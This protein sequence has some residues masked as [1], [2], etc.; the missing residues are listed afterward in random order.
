MANFMQTM[1]DPI[2]QGPNTPQGVKASREYALAL[3]KGSQEPVNHW[4]QGI[5]NIVKALQGGYTEYTA[6]DQE[7]KGQSGANKALL[8]ALGINTDAPSATPSPAPQPMTQQPASP[9]FAAPPAPPNP[10]V[11][12]MPTMSVSDAP[13]PMAPQANANMPRG[14][15]NNNPGNIEDGPFAQ[16]LPGYIGSDGRFAKFASLDDG[17]AAMETLLRSYGN[18]GFNTPDAIVNRWAPPSDNNPTKAYA[19]NIAKALGVDPT[20]KIDLNNPQ[21]MATIRTAM[22]RQENGPQGFAPPMAP[23][24]AP[25]SAGVVPSSPA[26]TPPINRQALAQVLNDPWASPEAKA[27]VLKQLGPRDPIKMGKDDRLVDARTYQTLTGPTGPDMDKTLQVQKTIADTPEY[28]RY[29][30]VV[31]LVKDMTKAAATPGT[32]GDVSMLYAFAKIMDPESVVREGEYNTL[33]KLQSLPEQIRGNIDKYMK[34]EASLGPRIRQ[35]LMEA[36]YNRGDELRLSAQQRLSGYDSFIRDNRINPKHVMPHFYEYP[37][38]ESLPKL[39]DRSKP[40]PVTAPMPDQSG[41]TTIKTKN[42]TV[43]IRP[44]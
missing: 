7:R 24:A 18:R 13:S 32:A 19:A 25:V 12:D 17:N 2:S 8:A 33:T 26:A 15:R 5:G 37:T 14:M 39:Y 38:R 3:L 36:A 16:K 42:G 44:M 6:A 41:R 31:P 28:K 27:M 9:Q 34:G 4:A 30:T 11:A 35:E 20:T 21:T 23:S 43:T 22:T 10:L 29:S 40:D 1:M